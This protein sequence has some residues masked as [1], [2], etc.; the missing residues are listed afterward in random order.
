MKTISNEGIQL[1]ARF[2]GYRS[3][4][5]KDA[6]GVWTIGYGHTGYVKFY[7]KNVCAGMT[8]TKE[9]ALELLKDDLS[10]AEAAVNKYY[11]RYTW[12]QNEF[13]ALVSFAFNVGSINQLTANGIR[14]RSIIA[15]KIL[16]YNK[17]GEKTLDGLTKRR[18][19][20]RELFL[21]A[22]DTSGETLLADKKE[23]TFK[24]KVTANSLRVRKGPGTNFAQTGSIKDKGVYTIIKTQGAWGYLKSGAGWICLD[25]T[26]KLG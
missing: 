8:I 12:N 13:D 4:A 9:Q 15:E 25:Y 21:T 1:I 5:Y 2:E 22:L 19:A 20:E 17:A 26:K 16:L 3:T 14:S 7:G 10:K 24:V 11:S 6:A 23:A 18:K